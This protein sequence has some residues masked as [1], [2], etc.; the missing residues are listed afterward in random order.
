MLKGGNLETLADESPF[1]LLTKRFI[2]IKK[3]EPQAIE[4]L[5]KLVKMSALPIHGRKSK[6]YQLIRG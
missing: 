2:K 4:T 6:K 5:R 1:S 3:C